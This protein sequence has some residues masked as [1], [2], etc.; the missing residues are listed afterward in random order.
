VED[1]AD[2][3]LVRYGVIGSPPQGVLV[4]HMFFFYLR[5]INDDSKDCNANYTGVKSR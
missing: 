4:R 1:K 3:T 5:I 2:E